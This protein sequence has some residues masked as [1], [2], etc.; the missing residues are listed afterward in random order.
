MSDSLNFTSLEASLK[1]YIPA[2]E[3]AEVKNAIYGRPDE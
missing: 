1:K 2:A 3:L